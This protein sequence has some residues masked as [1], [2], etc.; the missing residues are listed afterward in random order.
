MRGLHRVKVERVFPLVGEYRTR[1]H[2]LKFRGHNFKTEMKQISQRRAI[3][4]KSILQS[5]VEAEASNIFQA[6]IAGFKIRGEKLLQVDGN[7][8]LKY[9]SDFLTLFSNGVSSRDKLAHFV[10][11]VMFLLGSLQ[12]SG[13]DIG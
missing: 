6:K 1:C 11:Q 7:M 4:C 13:M 12:T 3:Y 10:P 9:Q 2:C 8:E 5:R